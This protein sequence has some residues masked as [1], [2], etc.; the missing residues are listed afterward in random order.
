MPLALAGGAGWLEEA[1]PAYIAELDISD[2]VHLLGYVSEARLKWLYQNC[3]A[4]VYPSLFE[5]FGLPVLE[6]MSQGAAVITSDASSL[7]EV[8]GDAAIQVSPTD[9]ELLMEAMTRLQADSE[10]RANLQQRA[11]R[12]AAGFSWEDSARKLLDIYREVAGE[13]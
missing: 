3:Y 8:S 12:R 4:F 1:L 11:L 5:G 6:A 2:R 7:P 13:S 10:L 9:T